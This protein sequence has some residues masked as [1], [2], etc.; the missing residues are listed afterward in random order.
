MKENLINRANDKLTNGK[1]NYIEN[2][3]KEED[4]LNNHTGNDSDYL[5]G[6]LDQSKSSNAD[7]SKTFKKRKSYKFFAGLRKRGSK[8]YSSQES[9]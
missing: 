1:S 9:H 8:L 5:N 6:S 2:N 7:L 4:E 3:L